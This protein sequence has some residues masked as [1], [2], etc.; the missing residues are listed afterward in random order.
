V[1]DIMTS[2]PQQDPYS[3][4][5]TE[6]LKRLSLWREQRIHRIITLEK[7]GVRNPSQLPRHIRSLVPRLPNYL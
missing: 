2:P 5:R 1:E 4:L 3:K 6:L 7:M